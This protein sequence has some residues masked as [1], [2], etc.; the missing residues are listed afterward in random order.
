MSSHKLPM[1]YDY[2]K[3]LLYSSYL[4]VISAV[5]AYIMNKVYAFVYLILLFI[6]SVNYWRKPEYGLRRNI[7]L[8]AVSIGA[9]YASLNLLL[10]KNEFHRVGLLIII[11]CTITLF[12]LEHILD[13]LNSPKWIVVHMILHI[14]FVC[15][16]LLVIFD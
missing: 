9:L 8:G 7:D 15:G 4:I 3:Y 2:S 12:I 6:T 13:Y 5:I 10:L 1:S 14:Y 11:I 16:T